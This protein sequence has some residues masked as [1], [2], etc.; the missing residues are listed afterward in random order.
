MFEH[1]IRIDKTIESLTGIASVSLAA[2]DR[3]HL[4]QQPSTQ[5][6]G[7]NLIDPFGLWVSK[8]AVRSVEPQFDTPSK[9]VI[10]LLPVSASHALFLVLQ[11]PPHISTTIH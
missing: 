5:S 11:K 1:R 7:I 2:S 8:N 3:F 9:R 6:T 10:E 4:L